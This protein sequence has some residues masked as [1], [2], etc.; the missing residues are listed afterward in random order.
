MPSRPHSRGAVRET[1][2]VSPRSQNGHAPGRQFES[3]PALSGE[4]QAKGKTSPAPPSRPRSPPSR[5]VSPPRGPRGGGFSPRRPL[6]PPTGPSIHPE[7]LQQL[8]N[9]HFP[10]HFRG[11]GG[12]RP[13]PPRGPSSF[14]LNRP[15]PRDSSPSN[16]GPHHTPGQSPSYSS[17]RMT[18]SHPIIR[19]NN[20]VPLLVLPLPVALVGCL[21]FPPLEVPP[22]LPP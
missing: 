15:V 16:S 18:P 2:Q 21:R 20:S 11:H 13:I 1:I 5:A 4:A 7:R 6:D 9:G 3:S 14:R 8:P 12:S 22:R 17:S 19:I 10:G